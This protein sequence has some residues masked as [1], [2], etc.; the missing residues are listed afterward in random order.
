[1]TIDNCGQLTMVDN[2]QWWTMDSRDGKKNLQ[3]STGK[4]W[5][6][7]IWTQFMCKNA[8][9]LAKMQ[10]IALKNAKTFLKSREKNTKN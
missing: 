5:V 6:S 9:N 3:F 2:G 8:Q 10:K 7:K 4:L 1:M